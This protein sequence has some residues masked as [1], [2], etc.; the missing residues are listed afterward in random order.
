[1]K[2]YSSLT[3]L[4]FA[5]SVESTVV[6]V[7]HPPQRV[8]RSVGYGA[9]PLGGDGFGSPGGLDGFGSFF[10]E[11]ETLA[12]PGWAMRREEELR[13][14]MQFDQEMQQLVQMMR[15]MVLRVPNWDRVEPAP[16]ALDRQ[17]LM[18]ST[19]RGSIQP[20][21][22][23]SP[24]SA[25]DHGTTAAAAVAPSG[26]TATHHAAVIALAATVTATCAAL[27]VAAALRRRRRLRAY[28]DE[29]ETDS[30]STSLYTP[31]LV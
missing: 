16:R 1:M 6:V 10:Q 7:M 28:A 9:F 13:E 2:I 21:P 18:F 5:V 11:R 22:A 24:A 29:L 23:G 12:M 8:H 30:D 17:D 19:P 25:E 3:L 20:L 14:S 4:L 31:L 27:L 15:S 26:A